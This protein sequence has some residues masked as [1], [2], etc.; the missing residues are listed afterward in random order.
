MKAMINNLDLKDDS[1]SSSLMS[2]VSIASD[3]S[4]TAEKE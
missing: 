1:M 2:D 3:S 4:E